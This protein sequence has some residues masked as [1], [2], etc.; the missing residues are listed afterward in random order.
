MYHYKV[1]DPRNTYMLE[2]PWSCISIAYLGVKANFPTLPWRKQW[3][4]TLISR[5]QWE[6]NEDQSFWWWILN[7]RFQMETLFG[8]NRSARLR[9]H[10][11]TQDHVVS[12]HT[13]RRCPAVRHCSCKLRALSTERA[14]CLGQRNDPKIEHGRGKHPTMFNFRVFSQRLWVDTT[15]YTEQMF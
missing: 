9:E 14:R 12:T 4:T 11:P 15:K 13:F 5:V 3:G 2:K 7:W 6:F 1:T 10:I 8:F